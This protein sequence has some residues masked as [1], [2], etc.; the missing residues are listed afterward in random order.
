MEFLDTDSVVGWL[1]TPKIHVYLE[2]QDVILFGNS[3]FADVIIGII[4]D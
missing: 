2:P 1:M 4:L 3:V